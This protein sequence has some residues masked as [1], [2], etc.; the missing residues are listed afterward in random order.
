MQGTAAAD[1]RRRRL[2]RWRTV[3]EKILGDR[4]YDGV[5]RMWEDQRYDL[6]F[7]LADTEMIIAR[8]DLVKYVAS[9]AVVFHRW[10]SMLTCGA[11]DKPDVTALLPDVEAEDLR[12]YLKLAH[13]L[14]TA[15]CHCRLISDHFER[16]R[17]AVKYPLPVSMLGVLGGTKC[18]AT[19][20]LEEAQRKIVPLVEARLGLTVAA[21]A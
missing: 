1:A 13:Q 8:A 20:I 10:G 12:R 18:Y 7:H 15:I 19:L 11:S 2:F 21:R 6:D 5:A 3:M 17:P 14:D 4:T 16:V 9:L